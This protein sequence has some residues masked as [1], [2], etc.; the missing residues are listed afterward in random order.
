[1]NRMVFRRILNAIGLTRSKSQPPVS[2]GLQLPWQ[3]NKLPRPILSEKN[4]LPVH[5]VDLHTLPE[6][7]AIEVKGAHPSANYV[8]TVEGAGAERQVH[9][10]NNKYSTGL[11]APIHR[12]NVYDFKDRNA[13][14][15]YGGV[16]FATMSPEIVAGLGTAIKS[17]KLRKNHSVVVF[18][19]FKENSGH[20]VQDP[21]HLYWLDNIVSL[22][23]RKIQK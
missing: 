4:N 3:P 7:L 17:N 9:I 14:A 13:G 2:L 16:N 6:S 10:W 23:L 12:L 15:Q 11:T 8:L 21:S 1:M 18:P 5:S 22:K 20:S 19:F